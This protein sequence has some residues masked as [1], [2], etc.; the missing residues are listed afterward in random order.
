MSE[1]VHRAGWFVMGETSA[2]ATT[3][4]RLQTRH[5]P[6]Q[7]TPPSAQFATE[8]GASESLGPK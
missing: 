6:A 7:M 8:N 1:K 4:A 3:I 5:V 2:A